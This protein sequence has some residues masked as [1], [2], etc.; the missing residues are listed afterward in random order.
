M[1]KG[2]AVDPVT[3]KEPLRE[4]RAMARAQVAVR[5]MVKVLRAQKAVDWS[6]T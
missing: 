6:S 2:F 4:V 1:E 5:R 3:V